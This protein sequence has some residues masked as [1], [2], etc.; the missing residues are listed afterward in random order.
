MKPISQYIDHTLLKA[1]A[2]KNDIIKLCDEAKEYQDILDL[3]LSYQMEA[4]VSYMS[5]DCQ[6]RMFNYFII[7]VLFFTQVEAQETGRLSGGFQ[8]RANVF[9]R[10]SLIGA[11]EIPQYDNEFVGAEAWLDLAYSCAEVYSISL[12][13]S[14]P[15]FSF[16]PT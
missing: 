6:T 1:T 10:D 8:A 12:L 15:P 13:Y 14:G 11:D 5:K 7:T 9:L 3:K 16:D 2:T 4:L